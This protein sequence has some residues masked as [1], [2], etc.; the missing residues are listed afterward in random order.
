METYRYKLLKKDYKTLF[1]QIENIT[2]RCYRCPYIPRFYTYSSTEISIF[3]DYCGCK[4]SEN[5]YINEL[6][7]DAINYIQNVL[8]IYK[9]SICSNKNNLYFAYD[10]NSILCVQCKSKLSNLQINSFEEI[11]KFCL[12]HFENYNY[13][14]NLCE[15]CVFNESDKLGKL[16]IIYFS[17]EKPFNLMKIK[18][19]NNF[20]FSKEEIENLKKD[21]NHIESYINSLKL[22]M[23]FDNKEKEQKI[24]TIYFNISFLRS[25]IYTYE[26]MIENNYINYNIISNLRRIKINRDYIYNS[27][28]DKFEIFP[29]YDI[30]LYKYFLSIKHQNEIHEK[31]FI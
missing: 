21:I 27:M 19:I 7:L 31:F 12:E 11:D 1:K 6:R 23:Y 28:N 9:C 29:F 26:Q 25:L 22:P 15:D 14:F 18:D 10:I 5:S 4:K 2:L 30:I 8:N 17:P 24:I 20:L 16:D 13:V 3:C